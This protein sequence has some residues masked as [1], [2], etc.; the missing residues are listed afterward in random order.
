MSWAIKFSLLCLG[1]I[2]GLSLLAWAM[3]GFSTFG[4]DADDF[5]FLAL[6]SVF[7]CLLAVALMGAMFYSDRSGKDEI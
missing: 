6:G 1:G 7:T 2:A 5:K 3:T 4:L